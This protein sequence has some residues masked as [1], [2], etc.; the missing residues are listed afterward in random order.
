[1][2]ARFARKTFHRAGGKDVY[3]NFTDGVFVEPQM[4]KSMQTI[5]VFDRFNCV[6]I[7]I[8]PF[9]SCTTI[10]TFNLLEKITINRVRFLALQ[11]FRSWKRKIF[12]RAFV[13]LLH[14]LFSRVLVPL[15]ILTHAGGT[16]IFF[17]FSFSFSRHRHSQVE[18]SVDRHILSIY[19]RWSTILA[20]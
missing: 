3:F 5:E 10:K 8:Q 2:T 6:R 19:I 14:V 20:G 15:L 12:Y 16:N 13:L 17:F 11:V 4:L 7:Q 1:M 9:E 18:P